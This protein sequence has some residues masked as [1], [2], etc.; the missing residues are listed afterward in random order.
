MMII[1]VETFFSFVPVLNLVILIV[2]IVVLL[3][4]FLDLVE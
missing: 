3:V 4:Q 2:V 1:L